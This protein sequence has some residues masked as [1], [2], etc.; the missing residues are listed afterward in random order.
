MG[1]NYLIRT[2]T[3]CCFLP[4]FLKVASACYQH[5]VMLW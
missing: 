2:Y 5:F 1:I 3:V 4:T